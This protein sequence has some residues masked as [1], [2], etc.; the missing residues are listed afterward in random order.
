MPPPVLLPLLGALPCTQQHSAVNAAPQQQ[1]GM[2]PQLSCAWQGR[3][4]GGQRVLDL[5]GGVPCWGGG[6]RSACRPKGPHVLGG[7]TS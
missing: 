1:Q 2:Q 5:Q 4:T 3:G 6:P 7:T